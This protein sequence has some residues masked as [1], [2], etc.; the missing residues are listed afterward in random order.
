VGEWLRAG[1][2]IQVTAGSLYGRFGKREEELANELLERNWISFCGHR[3]APSREAA[4]AFE[5]S[6]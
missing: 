6:I 2:L 4:A 1:C 3:C 5:A